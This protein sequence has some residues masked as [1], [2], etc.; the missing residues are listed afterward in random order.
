VRNKILLIDD[1][2]ALRQSFRLW[3]EEYDVVPAA[4]AEEALRLLARPN[5]FDLILLDVQMPGMGGLAALEKIKA[6]SPATAVIIMTGFSTK[7]VA[8][9]AL[10]GKASGYIEKP[11]DLKEMRAAIERELSSLPGAKAA[12]ADAPARVAHVKRFVEANCFKKITLAD[13]AGAVYLSPKYLS[14]L[15]RE[16]AGMGFTEYKL[17]V[18]IEQAQAILRSGGRNIKQV[19]AKLGYANTESFIRQFKKI[20]GCVPSSFRKGGKCPLPRK[21]RRP[22]P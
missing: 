9:K 10:K 21:A 13:A 6:L 8:I 17:K 14:R 20:A 3:F 4:S 5:E 11:F 18:K 15:F 12:D 19:S 22:K 7:D 16:H 1:N 2:D